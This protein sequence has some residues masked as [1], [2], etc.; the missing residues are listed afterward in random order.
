MLGAESLSQLSGLLEGSFPAHVL[1]PGA[2]RGPTLD[3]FLPFWS[4]LTMALLTALAFALVAGQIRYY[5]RRVLKRPRYSV[6][7]I[8]ALALAAAG[9][10]VVHAGEFYLD[11]ATT[12]LTVGFMYLAVTQLLRN[13]VAAYL[14]TGFLLAS[15]SAVERLLEQPAPE[16]QLQACLYVACAGL[17][18]AFLWFRADPVAQE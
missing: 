5:I 3:S 12:L 9:S 18:L 11:V 2:G 17:I 15:G 10:R 1:S 16:Y 13:N 14:L 8:L 4:E 6:L 7:A